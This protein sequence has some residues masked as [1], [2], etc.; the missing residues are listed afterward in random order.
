M[1]FAHSVLNY[2]FE[3]WRTATKR[4][5]EA[6]RAGAVAALA[7]GN[8]T[9]TD[10][11]HQPDIEEGLNSLI[12][13]ALMGST[14]F[15][16]IVK[17]FHDAYG[18]SV[19]TNIRALLVSWLATAAAHGSYRARDDLVALNEHIVLMDA[20][21]LLRTQY[22]GIG[23]PRFG[24]GDS[25]LSAA[26]ME[27]LVQNMVSDKHVL[28]DWHDSILHAVVVTGRADLVG[29][30]LERGHDVD[31][32]NKDND[33]PLL[34]AARCGYS[35]IVQLLLSKGASTKILNFRGESALHYITAFDEPEIST[36]VTALVTHGTDLEAI[37]QSPNFSELLDDS[38]PNGTALHF[39]VER[40]HLCA[41][42][43]LLEHGAD[44]YL[45]PPSDEIPSP[46]AL[47]AQIHYSD[48]LAVMIHHLR[49]KGVSARDITIDR[50]TG[51]SL[52]IYAIGGSGFG[53]SVFEKISRHGAQWRQR[54]VETLEILLD[55]GANEHLE[56]LPGLPYCTAAFFSIQS[57]AH[58]VDAILKV[59]PSFVNKPARIL[60]S[61][62][63]RS[64]LFECIL[65]H[66]FEV[67]DVLL[68]Y[69]VDLTAYL[70]YEGDNITALYYCAFSRHERMDMVNA[71]LKAG[72]Q[73]DGGP[74]GVETPFICAVRNRAF[75]LARHL[76]T[77]NANANALFDRGIF[78]T[79]NIPKTLLGCLIEEAAPA[80]LGCLNF[81]LEN[82]P[83]LKFV[84]TANDD[85]TILH[86]I[87]GLDFWTTRDLKDPTIGEILRCLKN[88]FHPDKKQI[89]K[90]SYFQ[91]S[92]G[93]TALHLAAVFGNYVVADW[94]VEN[95]ADTS[96][97]EGNGL[98]AADIAYMRTEST[99]E[100]DVLD[101][102]T[103]VWRQKDEAKRV[104]N[105]VFSRILEHTPTGVN[106]QAVA[107]Y[108]ILAEVAKLS[109][110]EQRDLL[111]QLQGNDQE[112]MTIT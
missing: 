78:I 39:A 76:L 84:T 29:H 85:W 108:K 40:N 13:G 75:R 93:T 35:N 42:R 102:P 111:S 32:V 44:L 65:Y 107:R 73:V 94:L 109:L 48:I 82:V 87:A 41:V 81:L 70:N 10:L 52:L 57:D 80:M 20:L 60:E 77:N 53:T 64:P 110:D 9:G 98:T 61:D 79:H 62:E 104:R 100:E 46:I 56:S 54:A 45:K 21:E 31:A 19:P 43:A 49:S 11:R 34:Y 112:S 105:K 67:F 97:L 95:G 18:H 106:K 15:R 1:T 50:A 99:F 91:G 38:T 4:E 69:N 55:A 16:S 59:D 36:I 33:T 72:V 88:Y 96:L 3:N 26:S 22:C 17:R 71:I 37:A 25:R 14:D 24:E 58:I 83:N 28:N 12:Q 90:Q 89:N 6:L 92:N 51:K 8:L 103:A 30:L 66:R 47:A 63:D 68:N 2:I 5:D 74:S 23:Q 101:I 86:D 7:I 27:S